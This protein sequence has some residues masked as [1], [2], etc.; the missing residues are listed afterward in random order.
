M[1]KVKN[2]FAKVWEY[3]KSRGIG[4]YLLMP[5]IV[6]SIVIP[7]VYMSA[8][9]DQDKYWNM[10]AFCMPFLAIAAYATCFF[11]YTSKYT[12][13]IMFALELAGLLLFV[14]TIYYYIADVVFKAGEGADILKA[15]GSD[16]VFVIVAYAIN[17]L[18]CGAAAFF[19]QFREVKKEIPAAAIPA[20]TVEEEA[21]A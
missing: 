12:A 20:E 10:L 15:V 11:K 1:E 17:I 2:F 8:F 5:V 18:V 4:F 19:K 6:L 7:F 14:N 13:V 21:Q 9:S 3:L 16:V